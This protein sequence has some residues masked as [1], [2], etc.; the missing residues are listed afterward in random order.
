MESLAPVAEEHG[1]KV[2]VV[3]PG[4]VYGTNFGHFPDINRKTI[5]AISGPYAPTFAAY[6]AWVVSQGWEAAG[7]KAQE[8]AEIVVSTLDADNPPLRVATN[9]WVED[10]LA[11]KIVDRDGSAVQT[12]ARTWIGAD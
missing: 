11:A 7:Q 6:F 4:F 2:S 10:Y 3:V 1:V 12:L 5:Q 9:E 8:V